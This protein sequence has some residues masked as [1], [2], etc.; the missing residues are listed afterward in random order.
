M[1]S[2]VSLAD[3]LHKSDASGTTAGQAP[4]Q[5]LGSLGAEGQ[6]VTS[7]PRT[8]GSLQGGGIVNVS[9]ESSLAAA[10]SAG[11][12]DACSGL[13]LAK[14]EKRHEDESASWATEPLGGWVTRNLPPIKTKPGI[15]RKPAHRIEIHRHAAACLAWL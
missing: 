14:S 10:V 2:H 3:L 6:H 15:K 8:T 12:A 7:E 11:P 13:E 5:G 4:W 1:L 9:A